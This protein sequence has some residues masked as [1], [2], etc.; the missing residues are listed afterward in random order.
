MKIKSPFMWRHTGK[1]APA[2][3]FGDL[4]PAPDRNWRLFEKSLKSTGDFVNNAYRVVDKFLEEPKE[5]WRSDGPN[6]HRVSKCFVSC[7]RS[8]NPREEDSSQQC[9]PYLCKCQASWAKFC[10]NI[11]FLFT[12]AGLKIQDA[13]RLFPTI[14]LLASLHLLWQSL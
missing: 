10:G 13:T 11:T 4:R 5:E 12:T 1:S 8:K 9:P 7:M 14:P 2:S 3:C 6:S